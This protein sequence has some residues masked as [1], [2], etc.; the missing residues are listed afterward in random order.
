MTSFL[1]D[2]W[3]LWI[4]DCCKELRE[5]GTTKEEVDSCEICEDGSV[6]FTGN[7]HITSTGYVTPWKKSVHYTR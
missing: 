2:H 5:K 3:D 1:F 4:A 7:F 6:H